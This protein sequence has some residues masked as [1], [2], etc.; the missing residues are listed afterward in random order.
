MRA[1]A[2][3]RQGNSIPDTKPSE[4]L[5]APHGQESNIF[6]KDVRDVEDER[7]DQLDKEIFEDEYEEEEPGRRGNVNTNENLP[8]TIAT[9]VH[10]PSPVPTSHNKLPPVKA[11]VQYQ[12]AVLVEAEHSLAMSYCLHSTW[13]QGDSVWM[14]STAPMEPLYLPTGVSMRLVASHSDA[15][16]LGLLASTVP[17]LPEGVHWLVL[18]PDTVYVHLPRLQEVLQGMNPQEDVYLGLGQAHCSFQSGIVLSRP[19][20][21]KLYRDLDSCSKKFVATEQDHEGDSI[22]AQ[23]VS[24][25]G[26][27]CS[28][29]GKVC[30]GVHVCVHGSGGF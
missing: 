6:D 24:A 4:S 1:R 27:K 11:S 5:T 2:A 9:T 20:F 30:L 17:S 25:Y 23:C 3:V 19:L 29:G 15:R 12:V 13:G 8:H 14:F 10:R 26:V 28:D 22:L 18:V 16:L 7:F 21:T